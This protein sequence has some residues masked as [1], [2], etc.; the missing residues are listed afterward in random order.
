M[1]KNCVRASP[2]LTL[3]PDGVENPANVARIEDAARLLGAACSPSVAGHLIAVENAP[4]A[5]S[6]YGR[7]PPRCD[8]TLAVG[9]EKRGLSRRTLA[10]ADET[11]QIPTQSRTVRT[12]N[13]AAAAAVAGWYVKHGS[14]P[15][16]QSTRPVGRRPGLLL[17]G[18][19][20]VE[21][22]SSLRS[23]A[24]FGFTDVLLDDRGAAWFDGPPSVRREA[25][26]AARR[27][28]NPL[29]IHRATLDHAARFDEIVLV[30]PWGDGTPTRRVRLAHGQRQLVIVGAQPE[31]LAGLEP[32]RV[33]IATLDLEPV[34]HAPLRLVASIAMAEVARQ[35]GRRRPPPGRA[36]ERAPTYEAA[37]ALMTGDE[38]WHIEAAELL[39]Y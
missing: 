6:I 32:E 36:G 15:Q 13:V 28:K 4:G 16:A 2:E 12:L 19:D 8:V 1:Q 34:E 38:V 23:A 20:H 17:I 31:Q 27:F 21:V 11:V 18:N 22:G 3:F 14:G 5:A 33:S 9:N 37:I 39:T 26:A 30:I 35:V 7:K 10:R 24:A 25:R 29:R